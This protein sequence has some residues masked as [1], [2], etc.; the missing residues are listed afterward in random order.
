MVSI[1]QYPTRK[2]MNLV[3]AIVLRVRIYNI[4]FH[5][6]SSYIVGH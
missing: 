3:I 1:W 2:L 6:N 5:T 4:S